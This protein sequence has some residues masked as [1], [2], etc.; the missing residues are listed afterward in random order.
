MTACH[1]RKNKKREISRV[2]ITSNYHKKRNHQ[3]FH[4]ILYVLKSHEV[5]KYVNTIKGSM[6]LWTI[7]IYHK[8][9]TKSC[10]VLSINNNC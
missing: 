1:L 2:K 9:D 5:P 4:F 7:S 3:S 10:L 8:K 6:E